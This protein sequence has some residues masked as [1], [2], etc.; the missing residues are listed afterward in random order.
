[1]P[2]KRKSNPDANNIIAKP[3]RFKIM[4]NGGVL[5]EV[6]GIG[7]VRRFVRTLTCEYSVLAEKGR[8]SGD[9]RVISV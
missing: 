3:V 2:R 6:D 1:M 8:D 9:W 4:A 7:E 5:A